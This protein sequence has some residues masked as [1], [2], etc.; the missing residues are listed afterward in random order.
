[1]P[2]PARKRDTLILG[3]AP[4]ESLTRRTNAMVRM[5]K[6]F[7]DKIQQENTAE[8]KRKAREEMYRVLSQVDEEGKPCYSDDDRKR[9]IGSVE[10]RLSISD[11]RFDVSEVLPQKK[12]GESVSGIIEKVQPVSEPASDGWTPDFT[13]SL[14]GSL[15]LDKK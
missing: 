7:F 14:T 5:V 9:I 13:K 1:M 12:R 4:P 11:S 2:S 15:K 3:S 6:Y 8:G 10:A